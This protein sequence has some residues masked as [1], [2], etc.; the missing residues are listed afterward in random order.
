MRLSSVSTGGVPYWL[1]YWVGHL[2]DGLGWPL[3]VCGL[4]GFALWIVR[5]DPRR[6]VLLAVPALVW[7]G[8]SSRDNEFARYTLPLVPFLALAFGLDSARP[9]V[10]FVNAHRRAIDL[11]SAA[12]LVV[13]GV[14]L[15]TNRLT[16]LSAGLVQLIPSWPS[17]TL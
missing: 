3:E 10:A 14:L 13:M 12:V 7:V 15:L 9:L 2:W 16:W 8:I 17:P 4:A 1:Y 5:R 11:G 6:L